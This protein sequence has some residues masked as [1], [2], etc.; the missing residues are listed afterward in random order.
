MFNFKN[1]YK[2][3]EPSIHNKNVYKIEQ[4]VLNLLV[5]KKN[6]TFIHK[7]VFNGFN[8]KNLHI[9]TVKHNINGIFNTESLLTII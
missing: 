9:I 5:K 1:V 8:E 4:N 7:N 2:I 6:V 3:I